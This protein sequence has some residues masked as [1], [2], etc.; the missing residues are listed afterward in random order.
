MKA[1]INGALWGGLGPR[2]GVS[3]SWKDIVRDT[4]LAGYDGIAMGGNEDTL[5][6]PRECLAYVRDHGLEISEWFAP[7]TYNPYPPNTRD[8]R[9]AMRYAARLGVKNVAVCGGFKPDPRRNVYGFDFDMFAG[10]L[11]KAL[12]FAHSL[13]LELAF[14]PHRGCIIETLFETK[15]LIKRLP[16]LKL[17]LD[18]AH[19][20]A[21]GDDAMR[22][23][24]AFGK[25]I[26]ATH[27]KDYSWKLN[28]FVE[29]GRGDSKLDV[30]A[31]ISQLDARGYTGWYTAELDRDWSKVAKPPQ[32]ISVARSIRRF[33][34]KCGH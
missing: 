31:C 34:R 23:I 13:G 19:V 28:S 7:V 5:G 25:R 26:I 29:P 18:I 11:G 20:E 22:F 3:F 30:A 12:E 24:R 14:H 15:Q 2:L 8:Y 6:K 21:S 27:I 10:N 9:R 33:L 32:A 16:D 4:S 17:M 1:S